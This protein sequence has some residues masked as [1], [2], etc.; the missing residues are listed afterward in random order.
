MYV[1]S[2]IEDE[3]CT[4]TTLEGNGEFIARV[5][6]GYDDETGYVY[7]LVVALSPLVGQAD[8]PG[9]ELTFSIIEA[10]DNDSHMREIWDGEDTKL[11]MADAVHRRVI[12][13][14]LDI[15]V[16]HLIDVSQPKVVSMTTHTANLPTPAL[17]KFN[18]ICTVFRDKGYTAGRVDPYHGHYAWLME[19]TEEEDGE[20]S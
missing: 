15:A 16:A 3:A 12:C 17:R 10:S 20:V 11:I 18:R 9:F 13:R 6:C 4:L 1:S 8:L 14:V 5:A 7:S 2:L 19:R